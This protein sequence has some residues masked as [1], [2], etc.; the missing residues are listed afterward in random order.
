MSFS[1]SVTTLAQHGD[2]PSYMIKAFGRW[3]SDIWDSV[4][5]QLTPYAKATLGDAMV[6]IRMR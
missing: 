3:K 5:Q 1:A 4:Y 6:P 2:I